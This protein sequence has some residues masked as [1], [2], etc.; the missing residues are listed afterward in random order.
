LQH[1]IY[2]ADIPLHI[3]YNRALVQLGLC[4]FRHGFIREAHTDLLDIHIQSRAKELLAQ[5]I[6]PKNQERTLEQEK[7]EKQR[8]LPFH[9]HINLE[10]LECAYLVSA[11][12]LGIPDVA[13]NEYNVRKKIITRPFYNQLR[14]NEEQSLIGIP[15]SMREHVI[16]ASKAM[17][18][19]NWKKCQEFIINDKMN[20]KVWN[21]FHQPDKVREMLKQKIKE[22]SLRAY[23]FTYSHIYDSISLLTLSEMFE[24]EGSIVHSIISKMII[25]QE[26]MGSLDEPTQALVMHRT[27]PSRIQGLS[28]QLMDKINYLVDF[29]EKIYEIKMNSGGSNKQQYKRN[30]NNEN[31]NDQNRNLNKRDH[32]RHNKGPRNNNNNKRPNRNQVEN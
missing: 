11:M 25:K 8:L 4:A 22:E 18:I 3:I 6:L 5:G 31:R 29:N 9:M 24:L 26:L 15:E 16:A 10:L 21:L 7:E 32:R 23:I 1:N 12:L 14:K 27:E 28:L 30:Y 19:G 17:R 2:K 20:N 13:A